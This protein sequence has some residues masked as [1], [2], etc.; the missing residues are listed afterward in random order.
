[1]KEHF[2]VRR[3]TFAMIL[4]AAMLWA[5]A[6]QAT[7]TTY[8]PITQ[9][10]AW[11]TKVYVYHT[12]EHACGGGDTT[13]YHLAPDQNNHISFLLTAFLSGKTVSL[14]YTCVDSYPEIYG[15]RLGN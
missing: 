12:E 9:L 7:D 14:A 15:V 1:M 13:R 11:P 4:S 6:A 2:A 5:G 10:K 3:I 8:E